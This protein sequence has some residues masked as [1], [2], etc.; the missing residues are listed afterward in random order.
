MAFFGKQMEDDESKIVIK[1]KT[2]WRSVPARCNNPKPQ[3]FMVVTYSPINEFIT[4]S[5]N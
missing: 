4:S 3:T 5:S 1:E 2:D